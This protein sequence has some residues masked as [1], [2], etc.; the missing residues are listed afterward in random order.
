M[1]DASSTPGIVVLRT[2]EICPGM[3]RATAVTNCI[4]VRW[5]SRPALPEPAFKPGKIVLETNSSNSD[6]G[7]VG[8]NCARVRIARLRTAGREW[9]SKGVR[10]GIGPSMVDEQESEKLGWKG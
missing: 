9:L 5:F 10:I 6:C 8:K 2:D 4:V 7:A 3:C 1:F